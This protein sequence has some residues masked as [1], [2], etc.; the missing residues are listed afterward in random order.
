MNNTHTRDDQK[1]LCPLYFGL[2][3]EKMTISFQY[4]LSSRQC[5][6]L[7]LFEFSYPFIIGPFLVPQ[8]LVYC[9]Y[10]AFIASILCTTKMEF[11]FW[12]QKEVRGSH[13]RRI[14]GSGRISNPHSLLAVMSTCYVWA[15]QNTTSR[16][17]LIVLPQNLCNLASYA[18]QVSPHITHN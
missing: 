11:Q 16:L 4:N 2:P 6:V 9:L 3:G 18:P 17:G 1:I 13:N 15:G 5:T 12:E 14:L 7:T 8:V 10:D